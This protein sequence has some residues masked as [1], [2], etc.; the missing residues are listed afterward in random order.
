MPQAGS[1]SDDVGAPELHIV[2][3]GVGASAELLTHTVLAQFPNVQVPIEIHPHAHDLQDI[4]RIVAQVAKA[5]GIILHTLVHSEIRQALIDEA[6]KQGV[7]AIDLAG[8]IIDRLSA[9]LKTEP[10]GQPG[11]YRKLYGQ[12]FE[13]VDAIEF[14][15]AHD[16]GQRSEEL[17][18]A[19]MVLM[20]V[21]RLG[22]TPL[23]VY[24][25]MQGWRVANLPFVPGVNLPKT[26]W[27]VDR[28]RVVG[29]TIQPP[30]LAMH[31]QWREKRLGVEVKDYVA[32]K[33]IASELREANR[34]FSTHDI[35]VVDVTDKPIETSGTEIVA[36]VT[37]RLN[38]LPR[39]KL[40]EVTD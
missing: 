14:T 7:E 3:G 23:S 9:R 6:E 38:S 19:E 15:I 20:G 26:L 31:R 36:V 18:E 24:L 30:Q 5:N 1:H 33:Q 40:S 27:D 17:D 37:R 25:A 10:V 29:L 21:S 34:F 16:D 13:R 32:Q 8:P 11:L 2:S 4:R 12:Y 39:R 28:R 22:K 35:P